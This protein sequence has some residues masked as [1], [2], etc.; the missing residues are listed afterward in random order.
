MASAEFKDASGN[1]DGSG[2]VDS[3]DPSFARGTWSAANGK[4]LLRFSNGSV[5]QYDYYAEAQ[6]MMF[7]LGG[8]KN[9]L[10]ERVR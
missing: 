6:S 3:G 10:W 9:R 4:L 8:G 2:S 1:P 7:K 5:E